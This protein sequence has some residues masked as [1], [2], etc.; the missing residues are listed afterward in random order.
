MLRSL[1]LALTKEEQQ[2]GK[3][4]YH[5]KVDH[6]K[7]HWTTQTVNV[8]KLVRNETNK[9]E[10]NKLVLIFFPDKIESKGSGNLNVM[11]KYKKI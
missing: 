11:N 9:N 7:Y 5:S 10:K 6:W 3:Q 2:P 8:N 4:S 1:L